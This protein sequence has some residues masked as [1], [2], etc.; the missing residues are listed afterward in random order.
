MK[1]K[2]IL[3][4]SCW[5]NSPATRPYLLPYK[6]LGELLSFVWKGVRI[7]EYYITF[8][9]LLWTQSSPPPFRIWNVVHVSRPGS[10]ILTISALS[11]N[12]LSVGKI[13]KL[14]QDQ[15]TSKYL[16]LPQLRP[17]TI[18]LDFNSVSKVFFLMLNWTLWDE[19]FS[20]KIVLQNSRNF[21]HSNQTSAVMVSPSLHRRWLGIYL[22]TRVPRHLVF[23]LPGARLPWLVTI[24]LPE[25]THSPA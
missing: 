16:H 10:T 3:F 5:L 1:R 7:K 11:K 21:L 25:H 2:H 8:Q 19:L 23:N 22:E 6:S 13:C 15:T 9:R 4:E 12:M 18:C 24:T 17:C 20:V 14:S